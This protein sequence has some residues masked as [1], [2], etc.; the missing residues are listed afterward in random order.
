MLALAPALAKP[1][2]VLIADEPTLGLA[3]LAAEEVIR[4]I[5]ELKDLGAAVLLVE[6]NAENALR[7]GN[8]LVFMELGNITWT[9]TPAEM[10]VGRLSATYLGGNESE[11]LGTR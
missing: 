6:E 9:G 1:P 11:P 4:A 3:P 5:V 7:L 10:D 8:Q 2:A